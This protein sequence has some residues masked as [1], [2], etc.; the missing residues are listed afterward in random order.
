MSLFR[1]HINLEQ[2]DD[3]IEAAIL[4][5]FFSYRSKV[6]LMWDRWHTIFISRD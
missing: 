3:Y 4:A 5:A 1:R 2:E 6:S